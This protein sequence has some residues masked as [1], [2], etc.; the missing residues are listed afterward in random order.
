MS[1][2]DDALRDSGFEV[3]DVPIDE[4]IPKEERDAM[5]DEMRSRLA[6]HEA[7]RKR[8]ERAA[9]LE[10]AYNMLQS[11]YD[12]LR[13]R[14][15]KR[16]EF[17]AKQRER[18]AELESER[19]HWKSAYLEAAGDVLTLDH[20]NAELKSL[21]LDTWTAYTRCVGDS[22]GHYTSL[23]PWEADKEASEFAERMKALGLI[24]D[25]EE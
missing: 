9:E 2:V 25:D 6:E 10:N 16:G 19:D 22:L 21:A 4:W 18:I 1:Y 8:S 5:R 17:I 15:T 3:R 14:W 12:I 23:K 24:G 7:Y 11:Q 13:E 20:E